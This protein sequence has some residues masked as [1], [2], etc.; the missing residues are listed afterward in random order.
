MLTLYPSTKGLWF[1][2]TWGKAWVEQAAFADKLENELKVMSPG[3]IIGSRFRAD[4]TI[5]DI[6]IPMKS[7]PK[8][9]SKDGSN[10]IEDVHGDDWHCVMTIPEN[11][12][13]L[14]FGKGSAC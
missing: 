7:L 6:L 1:G 2:G 4:E 8:I 5:D 14:S 10:Y 3:L 9:M 13:A 12:M 11:Q